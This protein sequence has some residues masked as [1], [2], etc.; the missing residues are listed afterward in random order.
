[1]TEFPRVAALSRREFLFT[2]AHTTLAGLLLAYGMAGQQLAAPFAEVSG[3]ALPED[4]AGA[5]AQVLILN[6]PAA[7][8][9]FSAYL[10]EILRTEGFLSLRRLPLAALDGQALAR[11]QVVLLGAGRLHTSALTLL[12]EFVAGGGVLVGFQADAQLDD[13]F[14]IHHVGTTLP[15][16]YLRVLANH[17]A[18]AGFASTPLQVHGPCSRFDLNGATPL[19][20][21]LAGAPLVAWQRFDAGQTLYWGYDLA[22]CVALLRQGNPDRAGQE[23]DGMDGIRAADLFVDWIDLERIAVPQADQQQRMLAALLEDLVAATGPPLPRLWY[24]PAGAPSV[25]VAT[26]DAHG[27]RVSHIEQLVGAVEQQQ[28]TV[29]IYYTPPP[30]DLLGR[31]RRRSRWALSELPAVGSRLRGADP[32]PAPSQVAAWRAR[33]HE[34]GMHP[35][36]EAGLAVGYNAYWNDFLKHGYGPLP[37][38]VRTHRILW[39]G[40]VENARIQ[41]QYGLRMNLDHYHSGPVVRRADGTWVYG[42]LSGTGLPMRFVNEDGA[43]MSV[44]QQPTHLV[45]EHLMPVFDTGFEVGLS[46]REA[47]TVTLEQI[48]ASVQHYP[49]ALGLQCHVDPFSKGGEIAATVATW[50]AATL[51]FAASQGLPILSAERW[52]AFVEARVAIQCLRQTWDATGQRLTIELDVP[53]NPVG[54]PMLM[55]PL[56]HGIRELRQFT[57]ATQPA[58]ERRIRLAGRDYAAIALAAGRQN[59]TAVYG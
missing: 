2:A 12:R 32:L 4:G 28:G 23:R 17:P 6:N 14:G 8:P 36:V 53:T 18:L 58:G 43:L 41:A 19:A 57:T 33:G 45:D 52:L 7:Q 13:L 42:Y 44:Y 55:L 3:L 1:M 25:L 40:W 51:A 11:V 39:H 30:V 20:T 15:G 46:G 56:R 37:P 31:E 49:A 48:A 5:Q 54:P 26:G 59:V 38:T 9:N 47:T 21:N 10:G 22:R 16:D 50:L 24:F 29:S 27:S 35:Y 34:F